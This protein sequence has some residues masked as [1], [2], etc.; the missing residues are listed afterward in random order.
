MSDGSVIAANQAM[1]SVTQAFV[2]DLTG[3]VCADARDGVLYGGVATQPDFHRGASRSPGGKAIICLISTT[4]DAESAIR[5]ALRPLE[6]VAIP[7]AEVH[8]V[9]TEYGT[10]YLFERS[11]AQRAVALIEIAHS[12]HREG[13]LAAAISNGLL[14]PGQTLRS[15]GAFLVRRCARPSCAVAAG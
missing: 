12:R 6:A 5:P 14:P 11:L 2:I 1:V 3:Q 15:R 7:R 13:L 4:D 10:A 8:Y 9:V